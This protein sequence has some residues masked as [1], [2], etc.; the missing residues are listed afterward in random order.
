MLA[1]AST[2]LNK[3]V[4]LPLSQ[5]KAAIRDRL[6][7]NEKS[8][9]KFQKTSSSKSKA[10]RVTSIANNVHSLLAFTFFPL[11][12]LSTQRGCTIIRE[13]LLLKERERKRASERREKEWEREFTLPRKKK[14]INIVP[15]NPRV[16]Y[17]SLASP[18]SGLRGPRLL[19]VLERY[20]IRLP[21]AWAIWTILRPAI[22]SVRIYRRTTSPWSRYGMSDPSPRS[23]PAAGDLYLRASVRCEVHENDAGSK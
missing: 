6:P 2:N 15:G 18:S 10:R 5:T 13:R 17:Y 4:G 12:L 23:R 3:C 16:K 20:K 7:S 22:W 1:D 11:F 9:A 21:L 8:F 14:F 19:P